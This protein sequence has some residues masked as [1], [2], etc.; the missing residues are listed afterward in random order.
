MQYDSL[1]VP[2]ISVASLDAQCSVLMRTDDDMSKKVVAAGGSV[3]PFPSFV[4]EPGILIEIP[5]ETVLRGDVE[6][7]ALPGTEISVVGDHNQWTKTA[8]GV[9]LTA[10]LRVCLVFFYLF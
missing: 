7:R 5:R 1:S 8:G 3:P 4:I 6:V 9:F 2:P 10:L